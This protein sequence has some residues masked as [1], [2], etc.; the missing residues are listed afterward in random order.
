MITVQQKRKQQPD[1][2]FLTSMYTILALGGF[3]EEG[4]QGRQHR[5]AACLSTQHCRSSDTAAAQSSHW[6][7]RRRGRAA[8]VDLSAG[9]SC[10]CG[11]SAGQQQHVRLHGPCL[12]ACVCIHRAKAS[13]QQQPSPAVNQAEEERGL[14]V[15]ACLLTAVAVTV[16][17]QVS[18]ATACQP[19]WVLPCY[20]C[21]HQVA[22][23][24]ALRQSV[25]CCRF[26]TSQNN[27]KQVPIC[28][29]CFYPSHNLL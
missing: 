7:V 9:S 15:W 21:L 20:A 6:E 11:H 16:T 28:S 12:D 29:S 26:C 10:C 2:G 23:R 5:L 22:A 17:Q 14:S 24:L 13:T 25:I 27:P 4:F 18:K 19:A 3:T 8:C 1:E